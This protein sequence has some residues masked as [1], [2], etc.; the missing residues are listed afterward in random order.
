M[1][2]WIRVKDLLPDV[3]VGVLTIGIDEMG[4]FLQPITAY[5]DPNGRF[6]SGYSFSGDRAIYMAVQTFATHWMPLP[7]PPK[8]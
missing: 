1:S 6:I 2:E 5:V 4:E 3:G 8:D 7:A